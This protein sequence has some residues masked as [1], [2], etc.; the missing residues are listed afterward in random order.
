MIEQQGRVTQQN[1]DWVGVRIGASSGCSACDQGKGC[2]A[3]IF[4][5]LLRRRPV[6]L[7]LHNAIGARPGQAVTVG[8]PERLFLRLVCMLY[9]VPLLAA[10]AGMAIGH[11]LGIRAGWNALALDGA[12][13]AGA[14]LA[15][16]AAV[17][18][19]GKRRRLSP[20][21]SEVRLLNVVEGE[22]A[23]TCAL[24]PGAGNSN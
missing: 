23:D 19:N 6:K 24:P 10:L 20:A 2:G 17:M 13:L 14:V 11:Y 21:S 22:A 3:G 4:G 1:G 12:A 16:G 8:I 5:R 15:G 18:M 9:L 7:Q